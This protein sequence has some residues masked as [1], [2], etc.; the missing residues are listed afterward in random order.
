MMDFSRRAVL[1]AIFIAV[2]SYV[3]FKSAINDS[4]IKF[5]AGDKSAFAWTGFTPYLVPVFIAQS[6]A[7]VLP[8]FAAVEVAFIAWRYGAKRKRVVQQ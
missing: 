4:Q 5:D 2:G 6:A 3:Q 1:A 8:V 7:I